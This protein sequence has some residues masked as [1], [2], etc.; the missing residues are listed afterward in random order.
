MNEYYVFYRKNYFRHHCNITQRQHLS[1]CCFRKAKVLEY[2]DLFLARPL[3]NERCTNKPNIANKH[4]P[5]SK[6]LKHCNHLPV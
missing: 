6:E 3:P 1:V 4:S 2:K 5:F